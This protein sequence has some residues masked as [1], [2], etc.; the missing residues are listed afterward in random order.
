[1]SEG[2][3]RNALMNHAPSWRIIQNSGPV[4]VNLDV[5]ALLQAEIDRLNHLIQASDLV[6]IVQRYPIRETPMIDQIVSKLH[7]TDRAQY[8]AAV[9]KLVAEDPAA[10]TL[11][12]G[13]F[14][15]LPQDLQAA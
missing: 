3:V 13:F 2:I 4:S 6:G 15:Q 9:R 5:P 11:M 8:E 7:F 12:L 14:G 10:K 1:M